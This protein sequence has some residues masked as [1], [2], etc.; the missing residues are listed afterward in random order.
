M[1]K[2]MNQMGGYPGSHPHYF[3]RYSSELYKTINQGSTVNQGSDS[4]KKTFKMVKKT[5]PRTGD[6]LFEIE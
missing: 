3:P 2:F 1:D 6:V 4:E 5:H